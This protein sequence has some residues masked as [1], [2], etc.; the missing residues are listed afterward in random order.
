MESIAALLRVV[1]YLWI[2]KC[3]S[4]CEGW[5]LSCG[6]VLLGS[7]EVFWIGLGLDH[8]KRIGGLHQIAE[9]VSERCLIKQEII[10]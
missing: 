10:T 4:A 3:C 2:Q 6:A 8:L 5:L 7:Q 1:L 9:L